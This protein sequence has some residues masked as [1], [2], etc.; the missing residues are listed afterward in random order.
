MK[1]QSTNVYKNGVFGRRTVYQYFDACL[2][3]NDRRFFKHF[4]SSIDMVNFNVRYESFKLLRVYAEIRAM[5]VISAIQIESTNNV[6][7][8]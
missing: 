6:H 3:S 5:F 4:N 1:S 8:L 7:C 2:I